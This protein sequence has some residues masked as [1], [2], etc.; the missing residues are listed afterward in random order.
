MERSELASKSGTKVVLLMG[1]R[2]GL[3][4]SVESRESIEHRDEKK[5]PD[6]IYCTVLVYQPRKWP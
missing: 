6:G 3:E 5:L 2:S 4:K 1:R